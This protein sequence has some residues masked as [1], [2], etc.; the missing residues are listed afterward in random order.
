MR[1]KS[2]ARD[3]RS[4]LFV[5]SVSDKEKSLDNRRV[6]RNIN[7]EDMVPMNRGRT[8]MDRVGKSP[9][10]PG[11]NFIKLYFSSFVTKEPN[12]LGLLQHW[13]IFALEGRL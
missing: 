1:L 9:T 3:K 5:R 8:K 10:P 7:L 12:N 11:E 2:L 6:G 13:I 4:S